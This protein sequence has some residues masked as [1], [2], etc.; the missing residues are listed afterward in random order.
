M[1]TNS[2]AEKFCGL[3]RIELIMIRKRTTRVKFSP[4]VMSQIRSFVAR[5]VAATEIAKAIGCTLGTLR[6]KC[7]QS[8]I[9]LRRRNL[10]APRKESILKRL[11]FALSD[12][13][14]AR[15]QKRAEKKGMT[16]ADFAVALLEAI[17][18]DNLYDAVI[19]GDIDEFT[20]RKF[21]RPL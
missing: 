17:V 21:K 13:V 1:Q 4:A 7:S 18:R 16:T 10:A 3:A 20:R 11:S 8:G 12:D 5:G 2:S 9:S 6:V 15:L 19:D 14:A